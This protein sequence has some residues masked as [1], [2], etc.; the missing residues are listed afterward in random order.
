MWSTTKEHKGA[1]YAALEEQ[2]DYKTQGKKRVNLSGG[3]LSL[4]PISF[5]LLRATT[6]N[7]TKSCFANSEKVEQ[8]LQEIKKGHLA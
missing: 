8:S 2:G 3:S 5:V 1:I 4:L 6:Q 7:K